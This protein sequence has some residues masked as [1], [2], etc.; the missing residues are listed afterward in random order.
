MTDASRGRFPEERGDW[1]RAGLMEGWGLR[2]Y[3]WAAGANVML[4]EDDPGRPGPG[5][6][7]LPVE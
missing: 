1:G 2:M 5:D 4:D 6:R 7:P 3:A